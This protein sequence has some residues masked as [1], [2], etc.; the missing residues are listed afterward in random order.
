[1]VFEYNSPLR[2]F[3]E[4]IRLGTLDEE[5]CRRLATEPMAALNLQYEEPGLVTEIFRATAG[6]ANL[7]T[8]ACDEIIKSLSHRERT[9]SRAVV[10]R[11]LHGF[12]LRSQLEGWDDL[13]RSDPAAMRANRLDRIVVYS[14]AH[15]NE[16][17]FQ[18]IQRT[19]AGTGLDYTAAEIR[20]S[21]ARLTL[22]VI[23]DSNDGA[24]Y[25]YCIPL[26]LEFLRAQGLNEARIA[27]IAEAASAGHG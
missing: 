5:A 9:I 24:N 1:M 23:A 10:N 4:Q 2:N 22:A 16:F 20:E 25:Y 17:T 6:R 18:D 12:E 19:V 21:L 7:M 3:G 8:T 14:T 26:F 11:V 27:A 13:S 15:D